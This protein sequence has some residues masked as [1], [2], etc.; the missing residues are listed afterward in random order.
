MGRPLTPP[1]ALISSA[2]SC[3]PYRIGRLSGSVKLAATPIWIGAAAAAAGG[4]GAADQQ[5]GAEARATWP[6]N[7]LGH[8]VLRG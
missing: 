6:K 1:A 7:T 8:V 2:A 3:A 4:Q 5:G